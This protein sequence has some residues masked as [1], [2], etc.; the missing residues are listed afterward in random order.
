MT[1]VVVTHVVAILA[2]RW[3]SIDRDRHYRLFSTGRSMVHS[4]DTC[5][6]LGFR[7]S[8]WVFFAYKDDR[9]RIAICS[10]Q[11]VADRFKENYNIDVKKALYICHHVSREQRQSKV[12]YFLSHQ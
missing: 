4:T 6:G 2:G 7:D 9:L 8:F 11:T 12:L 3:R 10:L 5:V 1:A